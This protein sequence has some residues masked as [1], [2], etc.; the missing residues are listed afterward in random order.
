LKTSGTMTQLNLAKVIGTKLFKLF[1]IVFFV[2]ERLNV[3]NLEVFKY[4][5]D[6]QL[7]LLATCC[8]VFFFFFFFFDVPWSSRHCLRVERLLGNFITQTNCSRMSRELFKYILIRMAVFHGDI[9]FNWSLLQ[10]LF[11]YA[12]F[13]F[14]SWR[15]YP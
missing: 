8:L 3:L 13:L 4:Y 11:N 6:Q 7:L 14:D 5:R 9:D 10:V 12:L 1:S 2:V 15:D